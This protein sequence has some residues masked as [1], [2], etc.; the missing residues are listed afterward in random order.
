MDYIPTHL[1]NE[2]EGKEKGT[3]GSWH[4]TP[5]AL[6]L[7]RMKPSISSVL[8]FD[9]AEVCPTKAPGPV[10]AL[11]AEYRRSPGQIK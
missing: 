6:T 10:Q 11:G 5:A 2:D 1:A 3:R 4:M 7:G 8:N 9:R